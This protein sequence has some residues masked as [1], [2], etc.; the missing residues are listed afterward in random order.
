MTVFTPYTLKSAS[1][2]A[3][4]ILQGIKTAYGFVPN[5]FSYMA[6]APVTLEAYL[7]LNKLIAK[8]SLTPAQAQTALL[9]VSLENKCDFCSTAHRAMGKKAGTNTG[10]VES[11]IHGTQ[12]ADAQDRALVELTQTIVRE[13]GWVPDV[14]LESFFA[15]GFTKQHVFEVI[16]IVTIK[17]LSNYSNH[18]TKPD[19]NPELLAMID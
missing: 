1:P 6:E 14:Q 13:R 7:A 18:L 12:I 11:L 17:T 15:A 2:D 5:L 16:L 3:Q 19:V 4:A 10:T 8:S 9:A